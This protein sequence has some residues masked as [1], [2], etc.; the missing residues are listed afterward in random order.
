MAS[1]IVAGD[2]MYVVTEGGALHAVTASN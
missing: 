1:P 2:T